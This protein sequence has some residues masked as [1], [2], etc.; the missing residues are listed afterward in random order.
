MIEQKIEK[1]TEKFQILLDRLA[2]NDEELVRLFSID[3]QFILIEF[4][5]KDMNETCLQ[6]KRMID[7]KTLF[8]IEKII[9]I[10]CL[11]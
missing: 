3:I 10:A 11:I 9:N 7:S 4:E 2:L 1:N 8:L 5:N 6:I